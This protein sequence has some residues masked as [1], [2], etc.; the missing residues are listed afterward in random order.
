MILTLFIIHHTHHESLTPTMFAKTDPAR[1]P[2]AFYRIYLQGTDLIDITNTYLRF[3]AS[4]LILFFLFF[5]IFKIEGFVQWRWAVVF[6]P[7]FIWFC[8]F[9]IIIFGYLI[10]RTGE[11]VRIWDTVC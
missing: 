2:L 1:K 8:V 11:S 9:L 5:F 4:Y 10:L 6:I 3:F 7:I